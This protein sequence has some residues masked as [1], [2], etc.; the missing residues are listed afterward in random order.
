MG[1]EWMV[2]APPRPP[3]TLNSMTETQQHFHSLQSRIHSRAGLQG[4]IRFAEPDPQILCILVS[5]LC[6]HF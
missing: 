5:S 4:K 2:G 3:G 1:T 6:F